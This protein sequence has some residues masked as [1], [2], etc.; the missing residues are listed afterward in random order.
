[1]RAKQTDRAISLLIAELRPTPII[2]CRHR[3]S[4]VVSESFAVQLKKRVDKSKFN[5]AGLDDD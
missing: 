4:F 3:F 1:M 5:S 2:M